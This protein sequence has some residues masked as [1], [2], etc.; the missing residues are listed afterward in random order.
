MRSPAEATIRGVV[1]LNSPLLFV[2]DSTGGVYV[3]LR[4]PLPL[5]VGDEVEVTGKVT[6]NG[7]SAVFDDASVRLLWEGIPV[8]PV[9]VTAFQASTGKFAA[10]FIE[11]QGRLVA[12]QH[13]PDNT[14]V[15]NLEDAGQ[16]FQAI[17]NP[18]RSAYIFDKLKL[19]SRL[20]LRGICVVDPAFTHDLTPFVILLRSSEDVNLLAGPPWWSA[21]HVLAVTSGVLL[22]AIG[23]VFVYQRVEN[24]QLRAVAA[25]A[26]T[27]CP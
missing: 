13:G 27:T 10:T 22:L 3:R 9:S 2:Q 5:K 1:I 26:R 21:G 6:P 18:G 19:E 24:W 12:K 17:M 20:N 8:A 4:Q 23:S 25:R 7:F 16:S 11:V 15:L 14:L